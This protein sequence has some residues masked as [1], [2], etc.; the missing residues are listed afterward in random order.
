[1]NSTLNG[2]KVQ[3]SIILAIVTCVVILVLTAGYFE[4][5][6]LVDK[7]HQNIKQTSANLNLK[8][9]VYQKGTFSFS[10]K[11]SIEETKT[12][13]IVNNKPIIKS[14]QI[15]YI[16][17]VYD[18]NGK[19]YLSFDDVKFLIGNAAIEAAKKDGTA[20]YEDGKYYVYDDY[21]ISNNNKTIKN[22]VIDNT[23]SLNVLGFLINP[24]NNDI[25]NQPTTY[26]TFKRV[27]NSRNGHMLCYIYTQND[28]VVKVEG[29][30][31]P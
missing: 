3:V 19:R 16:S 28:I 4:N 9:L 5:R 15:G 17:N 13:V 21:Y 14:K 12:Q 25:N 22:Y 27:A 10:K 2:P 18:K 26:S 24:L 30:Y 31:T 8:E 20:L 29:Q 23:A 6:V 1:M 7:F 11:V